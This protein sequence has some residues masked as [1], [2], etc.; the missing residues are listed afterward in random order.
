MATAR[1]ERTRCKPSLLS[2]VRPSRLWS[3]QVT[4]FFLVTRRED[5]EVWESEGLTVV[6]SSPTA[7][8]ESG[9]FASSPLFSA[10]EKITKLS[11]WLR[12]CVCEWKEVWAGVIRRC[13]QLAGATH[14]FITTPG[15]HTQ[16]HRHTHTDRHTH[17]HTCVGLVNCF[18][19]L[20]SSVKM[21]VIDWWNGPLT[22]VIFFALCLLLLTWSIAGVACRACHSSGIFFIVT[23]TRTANL[24][25][26]MV[27]RS[28]PLGS[29]SK[30]DCESQPPQ[31]LSQSTNLTPLR[32][33]WYCCQPPPVCRD[34]LDDDPCAGF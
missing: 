34:Q 24:S 5:T 26:S 22:L 30:C 21:A 31:W 25:A 19:S 12:C 17:T 1:L 2:S 27:S 14:W 18:S 33:Q 13:H 23:H 4:V 11:M 28:Q 3:G 10:K 20:F 9:L 6:T 32:G 8:S 29:K 16:T 7:S 15:C